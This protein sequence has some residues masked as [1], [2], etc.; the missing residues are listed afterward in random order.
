MQTDML[1]ADIEKFDLHIM[2]RNLIRM[3]QIKNE[4][5]AVDFIYRIDKDIPK[6]VYG[7]SS[8]IQQILINLLGNAFK[9]TYEGR[10]NLT[11]KNL[12]IIWTT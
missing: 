2:I 6:Q 12:K 1:Q 7:D 8:K 4:N 11:V 3:Y 5:N 9:F 10:V